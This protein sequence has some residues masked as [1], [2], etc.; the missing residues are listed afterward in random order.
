MK[1]YLVKITVHIPYPKEFEFRQ[2]ANSLGTAIN[3]AVKRFRKELS[4][5]KKIK[6]VFVRAIQL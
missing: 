1:D 2:E 4:G 6:E 5:R 3:R